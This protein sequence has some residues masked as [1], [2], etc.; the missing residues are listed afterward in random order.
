MNAPLPQDWSDANQACLVAEF[1]RLTALL[2]GEAADT[3]ACDATRQALPA[4]AAIDQLSDTFGLSRFERDL[5][6]L[7]AGV[8]L[9][10]RLAKACAA[11]QGQATPT[12]DF[13]LAL[14]RLD[15]PHW[16][17][18]APARPLRQWRLLE[19]ERPS[20]PGGSPLHIDERILHHLTGIDYLDPRL[21][22]LLR[23][24]E[25][26]PLLAP[27]HGAI[28]EQA[29]QRLEASAS[30]PAVLQ[31]HGSDRSG[32]EDTAAAI[33]AGLGLRL[34]ALEATDI[35]AEAQEL[36]ALAVLW[37]REAALLGAA[38]LIVTGDGDEHLVRRLLQRLGGLVLLS[39][40]EPLAL[41]EATPQW[42]IDR[43]EAA[44]QQQLWQAALGASAER[45]NG[46]LAGVAAQFQLS[47]RQIHGLG[48]RLA[49][50]LEQGEPASQALWSACR[51]TAQGSELDRLAQRIEPRAGWDDIV[52]PEAQLATLRQIATQLRHRLTVYEQWGFASQGPRGL[53]ISALFE[54][55]S[56][57]GKTLA[58]EVIA[59]AV[60]L[61]LYRIDL[62][63]VV[64]K[65]IGETE[66]NLRRVFDAAEASGAI[67]LFD[68]ADALF[69]KRSEVKDSHD[70]YANIEVSYLLQRMEAYRGLAILTTNH[71]AALDP[72]FQ[73]RLRF[74]LRFPFP[75]QAQ[76][77]AIWRGTFPDAAPLDGIDYLKLARLGA[78]GGAIR[79]IALNA[80]FLAAE[81]GSAVGMAQ[82]LRA[83][84][85]E[86][87]KRDKPPSEAET[88][89]WV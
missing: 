42:R 12:V 52:L 16:S 74:I 29:L 8:E 41:D 13:H 9:D 89:G 75:D 45:V 64:S 68:E 86:A 81:D 70:R 46:T 58:A 36:A 51:T 15:M 18:L 40:R 14:E 37:Q 72:A 28:V 84:R 4:P 33:A 25:S 66:K 59:H 38:L 43:P 2:A 7:C 1:A 21:E 27:A 11:A 61:D 88:R 6:L 22:P 65:Y 55:E 53:G 85:L 24:V 32:Q 73:R 79:N 67:L 34:Y 47:A 69:G 63:A 80:A 49:P 77:E 39:G 19:L 57:T 56:G 44:D 62:S 23:P 60:G 20:T 83:A 48:Q 54:G 31:L 35:P 71:K 5:L 76:R 50:A 26:A 3:A 30:F 78:T 10:G 82:L 17:A 87:A